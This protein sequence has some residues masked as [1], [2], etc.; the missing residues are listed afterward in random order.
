MSS[1]HL[2]YPA[3]S[4]RLSQTEFRPNRAI[5]LHTALCL[6]LTGR[7]SAMRKADIALDL[8][9]RVAQKSMNLVGSVTLTVSSPRNPHARFQLQSCRPIRR[10]RFVVLASSPCDVASWLNFT[11]ASLRIHLTSTGMSCQ[12]AAYCATILRC[13]HRFI[14]LHLNGPCPGD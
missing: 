7:M 3:R 13:T 8:F 2:D 11:L 10:R 5:Q 4:T 12:V 6:D 1:F 14:L 9:C